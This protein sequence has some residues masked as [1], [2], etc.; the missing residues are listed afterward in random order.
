MPV[1]ERRREQLR[2][3]ARRKRERDRANNVAPPPL[4]ER[5]REQL[6]ESARRR[7]E[8]NRENATA[9]VQQLPRHETDATRA[10]VTEDLRLCSLAIHRTVA[11]FDLLQADCLLLDPELARHRDFARYLCENATSTPASPHFYRAPVNLYAVLPPLRR[12]YRARSMLFH[13]EGLPAEVQ[14]LGLPRRMPFHGGS[15]ADTPANRH[16]FQAIVDAVGGHVDRRRAVGGPAMLVLEQVQRLDE[17]DEGGEEINEENA[18]EEE[19][20]YDM[21]AAYEEANAA[22]RRSYGCQI[23]DVSLA[24]LEQRQQPPR[25]R[26]PEAR[27][28]AILDGTHPLLQ[29]PLYRNTTITTFRQQLLTRFG[30]NERIRG[31]PLPDWLS[32]RDPAFLDR[33]YPPAS[34]L[35]GL[36]TVLIERLL[37]QQD[38]DD[39]HHL[40]FPRLHVANVYVFWGS[41]DRIMTYLLDRPQRY[42]PLPWTCLCTKSAR[43]NVAQ[44]TRARYPSSWLPMLQAMLRLYRLFRRHSGSSLDPMT[45]PLRDFLDCS[46]RYLGKELAGRHGM[47]ARNTDGDRTR[48]WRNATF[49][50]HRGERQADMQRFERALRLAGFLLDLDEVELDDNDDDEDLAETACATAAGQHPD[51]M[52][53][54]LEVRANRL[55]VRAMRRH[56]AATVGAAK[57]LTAFTGRLKRLR[58]G[59]QK[60]WSGYRRRRREPSNEYTSYVTKAAL[61]RRAEQESRRLEQRVAELELF[62]LNKIHR[63]LVVVSRT[64]ADQRRLADL[65]SAQH[66]CRNIVT[67]TAERAAVEPGSRKAIA[68]AAGHATLG[69]LY[70]PLLLGELEPDDYRDHEWRKVNVVAPPPPPDLHEY[71]ERFRVAVS[72]RSVRRS[73]LMSAKF[74]P[75]TAA[76]Y[77]TDTMTCRVIAVRTPLQLINLLAYVSRPSDRLYC[78]DNDKGE[79]RACDSTAQLKCRDADTTTPPPITFTNLRRRLWLPHD[80]NDDDDDD[81]RCWTTWR[82]THCEWSLKFWETGHFYVSWPMPRHAKTVLLMLHHQLFQ[83]KLNRTQNRMLGFDMLLTRKRHTHELWHARRRLD[84][85]AA[86]TTTTRADEDDHDGLALLVNLFGGDDDLASSL[87]TAMAACAA[88]ALR[89]WNFRMSPGWPQSVQREWHQ[90]CRRANQQMDRAVE[91][92]E[93]WRRIRDRADG[94][95]LADLE[96]ADVLTAKQMHGHRMLVRG[97]VRLELLGPTTTTED[98]DEEDELE[99]RRLTRLADRQSMARG[100]PFDRCWITDQCVLHIS[101]GPD[102]GGSGDEAEFTLFD[103]LRDVRFFFAD[104]HDDTTDNN[105][106]GHNRTTNVLKFYRDRLERDKLCWWRETV[107][108]HD[109]AVRNQKALMWYELATTTITTT[110]AEYSPQLQAMATMAR[111]EPSAAARRS[112]LARLIDTLDE[113]VLPTNVYLSVDDDDDESQ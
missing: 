25:D 108:G 104:S 113:P 64:E 65:F 89:N 53:E 69:E 38:N 22:A 82:D 36:Q 41:A 34:G 57:R 43:R 33:V 88:P 4:T 73:H 62:D 26:W 101:W 58:K 8:R 71:R 96:A 100:M 85:A 109:D 94:Y 102:D 20:L 107:G 79:G 16:V 14:Q 67:G 45:P 78:C 46:G 111:A 18:D 52:A 19:P 87:P 54:L 5:R 28:H 76:Y 86:T 56:A 51:A 47:N 13:W 55:K 83:Q 60:R 49:E 99:G 11:E 42:H 93:C 3:A 70:C 59:W 72:N 17:A 9:A 63:H 31:L 30:T 74:L 1:S 48:L 80:P 39:D 84:D 6:R 32:I 15:Y 95:T 35:H 90:V 29:E 40:D 66:V 2:Q 12:K 24:Y 44:L 92:Y 7:R 91:R 21:R 110:P 37:Q 112:L 23:C 10:A 61:L 68:T 81:N 75:A 106:N 97:H 50:R 27:T 77:F 98:E 105:N 103:S